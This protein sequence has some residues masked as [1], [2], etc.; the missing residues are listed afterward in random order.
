[1]YLETDPSDPDAPYAFC[2]MHCH[3]W[4]VALCAYDDRDSGARATL[5]RKLVTNDPAVSEAMEAVDKHS[6]I[7]TCQVVDWGRV[8]TRIALP[9]SSTWRTATW[10]S[11]DG[12]VNHDRR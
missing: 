4:P 6:G 3:V 10:R 9:D 8:Y 5:A 11:L 12:E 2:E 1:M 7:T